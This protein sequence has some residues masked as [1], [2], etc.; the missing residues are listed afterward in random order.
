MVSE[1][2]RPAAWRP[3]RAQVPFGTA[4]LPDEGVGFD[5]DPADFVEEEVLVT[6]TARLYDRDGAGNPMAR[7]EPLQYETR[8]LVRRPRHPS[9]CSGVVHFEALHPSGDRGISWENLAPYLVS[10]GHVWV[11]VT[12]T[13]MGAAALA[14]YDRDAYASISLPSDGLRWEILAQAA[15]LV[16]SGTG[17]L[18]GFG[19]ERVYASGWSYTG[20]LWRT[21]VAEGFGDRVRRPDSGPLFDGYV[22]A[23]SSG[24]FF[25]GYLTLHPDDPPIAADDPRRTIRPRPVPVIELLSECEAETNRATRRAD[26][27]EPDDRYRL[28]EVAGASH[29]N[30]RVAGGVAQRQLRGRRLAPADPQILETPSDFPMDRVA[31]AV[32]YNLEAWVDRGVPPPR[33]DRFTYAPEGGP[34]AGG[35]EGAEPLARDEHGNVL[36]GVRTPHVDVPTATYAPHSTLASGDPGGPRTPEGRVIDLGSLI[37]HKVPFDREKLRRLYGTPADYARLVAERCAELAAQRWL[38]PA[39]AAAIAAD[40]RDLEF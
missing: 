21:F 11:G 14:A 27:D 33:A 1:P 23:I 39:D 24:A 26:S 31:A 29:I 35:L 36:G 10:A 25:G 37:G 9:A 3:S 30:R 28:F 20:S 19:V 8:M 5:L 32:F 2:A 34:V 22:I 18:A 40:A 17:P 7:A 38:L 6:G 4:Y 15:A 16:R 13:N 12:V